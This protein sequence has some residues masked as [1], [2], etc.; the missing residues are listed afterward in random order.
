MADLSS[1]QA[2]VAKAQAAVAA[3]ASTKAAEGKVKTARSEPEREAAQSALAEMLAIVDWRSTALVLLMDTWDCACG[4]HDQSPQGIYLHQEHTR[5]A[6]STRLTP[7]RSQRDGN[8]LPKRV[9]L[10]HRIVAVCGYCAPELG[11]ERFLERP[12]TPEEKARAN[13]R[14]GMYVAE[15][16]D[17]RRQLAGVP[18]GTP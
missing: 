7:I 14:P 10:E 13:R 3:K 11:F 5:M 2:L 6:N 17:K 8:D 4:A 1:L 16:H 15:W 18:H 12:T 9:K